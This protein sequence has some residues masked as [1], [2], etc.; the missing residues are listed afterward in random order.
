MK[1]SLACAA[2]PAIAILCMLT[3]APAA[4]VDVSELSDFENNPCVMALGARNKAQ[5]VDAPDSALS[6]NCDRAHGDQEA[7][8]NFLLRTW[9]PPGS[10]SYSYTPP[11]RLGIGVVIEALLQALLAYAVLGAPVRPVTCLLA[12]GTRAASRPALAVG[13]VLALLLRLGIGSL[14][15]ALLALPFLKLLGSIVLVGLIAVA[16]RR[17]PSRPAAEQGPAAT[18]AVIITGIINDAALS[19]PGLLALAMLARGGWILLAV[20]VLLCL[21]ASVPQVRQARLALRRSR[22]A[23]LAS[24]ILLAVSVAFI[25]LYDPPVVRVTG[26]QA[27]IVAAL[28]SIGFALFVLW[29]AGLLDQLRARRRPV[30]GG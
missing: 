18:I 6:D 3:A 10:S 8:W 2:G 1:R 13:T 15:L 14:C 12:R 24:A 21:P 26:N 30:S 19:A 7:A 28:V 20:A 23:T 4:A 16:V 22:A 27:S 29:R 25:G 9:Q 11:K 17:Q 5:H